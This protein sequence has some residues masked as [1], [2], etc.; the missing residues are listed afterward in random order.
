MYLQIYTKSSHKTI[1]SKFYLQMPKFCPSL[2]SE[3]DFT[4]WKSS[5]REI[6]TDLSLSYEESDNKKSIAIKL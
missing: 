4:I 5:N 6:V 3:N 2:F 1:F